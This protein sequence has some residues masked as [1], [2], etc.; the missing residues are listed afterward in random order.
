MKP[1]SRLIG[2]AWLAV[3]VSTLYLAWQGVSMPLS[4]KFFALLQVVGAILLL[5]RHAAGWL[6]LITM[7]VF[8]MVSGLFALLSAPFLPP[9]M[10]RAAP[11]VGNLDP[12]WL[13]AL[14]A[15]LAILFGRLCWLN[16]RNNPP[17]DW[18]I[19]A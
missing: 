1:T 6:I 2:L 19:A 11:R 10:L 12:R 5:L 7:S 14:T 4:L 17:S 3:G 15:L 13:A 18:K 9:E 16:L 8:T